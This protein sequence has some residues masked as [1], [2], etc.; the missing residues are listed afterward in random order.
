MTKSSSDSTEIFL[1]ATAA[2]LP[3]EQLLSSAIHYIIFI[4]VWNTIQ[5]LHIHIM[6]LSAHSF[7]LKAQIV[8]EASDS[9]QFQSCV[10]TL[11]LFFHRGKSI[12]FLFNICVHR[13]SFTQVNVGVFV[14]WLKSIWTWFIRTDKP[15]PDAFDW[16]HPDVS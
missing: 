14:N 5:H 1:S 10:R 2:K 3:E 7:V 4:W 15:S 9:E 8:N 6:A 13:F 16:I 11:L 12:S